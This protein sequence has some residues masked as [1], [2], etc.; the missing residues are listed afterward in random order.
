MRVDHPVDTEDKPSVIDPPVEP[1]DITVRQA[2]RILGV[3]QR[4]VYVWVEAG[5]LP[6]Y[7]V[8]GLVRFR[9]S[10]IS[11][12]LEQRAVKERA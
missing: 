8:E 6:H 9:R 2:A 1:A 12:W 7:K 10:E 5:R 3:H 4:T 11:D